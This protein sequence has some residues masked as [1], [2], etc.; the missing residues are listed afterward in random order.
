MMPELV[1]DGQS[2]L[3]RF[4]TAYQTLNL[5]EMNVLNRHPERP[6]IIPLLRERDEETQLIFA[7]RSHMTLDQWLRRFAS[8]YHDLLALIE[9]LAE[10]LEQASNHCLR[11]EQFCLEPSRICYHTTKK[12]VELI[13]LPLRHTASS[14]EQ[15]WI[16]MLREL[17]VM[18]AMSL[19]PEGREAY[20]TFIAEAGGRYERREAYLKW[21]KQWFA[22][23][24]ER[25]VPTEEVVVEGQRSID[26]LSEQKTIIEKDGFVK[27]VA[28]LSLPSAEKLK[29]GRSF[30]KMLGKFRKNG[31]EAVIA[32]Q[33]RTEEIK[34]EKPE[35]QRLEV[36]SFRPEFVGTTLLSNQEQP[37]GQLILQNQQ[38][39]R[40]FELTKPVTRVGR[41]KVVC[42]VVID[43]DITIGRLHAEVHRIDQGYFL[44]DLDSLNG[45][46]LND[47]RLESQTLYKLKGNDVLRLSELEILFL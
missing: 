27:P 6:Y 18:S 20:L 37:K 33:F 38:P 14:F 25:R 23:D 28:G 21:I 24:Y 31:A 36:S 13:Y 22:A 15:Q 34:H 42:D 44:K 16:K 7:L 9:A 32:D 45:T 19:K 29:L 35:V 1:N 46:Y 40:V 43:Y 26:F 3:F 11:L 10:L 4:E 12:R 5:Y 47:Q 41:N 2:R 39:C 30:V 17:E 8:D